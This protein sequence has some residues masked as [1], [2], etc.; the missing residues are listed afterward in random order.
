MRKRLS[1]CLSFW[2]SACLI[3]QNPLVESITIQDG[4]SQGMIYDLHQ[5]QEGFIWIATKDGLNR[6]DGRKFKHFNHDPFDPHSI[7][8]NTVQNIEEDGEG[9][10]WIGTENKG[11]N[12]FDKTTELFFNITRQEASQK[13]LTSLSVKDIVESPDGSMWIGT[14]FGLNQLKWIKQAPEILT[15]DFDFEEHIDLQHFFFKKGEDDFPPNIISNLMISSKK[16]IWLSNFGQNLRLDLDGNLLEDVIV[17]TQ[18]QYSGNCKLLEDLSGGIWISQ[19]GGLY[20]DQK[21]FWEKILVP[22]KSANDLGR[23]TLDANGNVFGLSTHQLLW[24]STTEPT[25]SLTVWLDFEEGEHIKR[26][27][28]M[29]DQSSNIWIGTGGY[30]IRKY[31]PNKKHFQH[32]LEGKSLQRIF[33]DKEDRIWILLLEEETYSAKILNEQTNQLEEHDKFKNFIMD[34]I[35]MKDG[36][37][38]GLGAYQSNIK[39]SKIVEFIEGQPAINYM[40]KNEVNNGKLVEDHDGNL[41]KTDSNGKLVKFSPQ[42]KKIQTFSFN[43]LVPNTDQSVA[44]IEDANKHIWIGTAHGLIRGIPQGDS[45]YF[46][47]FQN[48]PKDASSLNNNFVLSLHDDPDTPKKRLWIGTKG[49]GLNLLNKETGRIEHFSTKAGLPNNVIYGILVDGEKH[50][51]MSTNRGLSKFNP[52]EKTFEN[53]TVTDGLQDNEFNTLSYAKGND[54]RL[55]FGGINGLTAFYPEDLEASEFKPP[56]CITSL[57]INNELIHHKD[58]SKVLQFPIE[59]TESITLKHFQNLLSFEFAAL[60]YTNSEKNQY[61]HFF[62]GVDPD[63]VFTGNDNTANYANLAPGEYTFY[64]KGS[65]S[66]GIWNEEPTALKVTILPPWW[67]SNLAYALYFFALLGGIYA[68]Y[69]FQINR[70]KLQNQLAFEQKEAERLTELDRIKTNF[71]SNITHE[72]RTP[73]TLIIEPIRQIISKPEDT[74]WLTK[75]RLVETN[76]RKLLELVNQLLDLSKLE[77]RQMNLDLRNGNIQNVLRPIYQSFLPLAEKKGIVLKYNA[78]MDLPEF[79]FDKNKVEKVAYN[80]LSNALKFTKEGSCELSIAMVQSEQITISVSDTGLGIS[81]SEL[82]KVFDRFYQVDASSTREGEGT[83]IGLALTKELVELMGGN[84]E[85]ESE[86]GKGST[87][88]VTLPMQQEVS[89]NPLKKELPDTQALQRPQRGKHNTPTS[90]QRLIQHQNIIESQHLNTITFPQGQAQRP[91]ILIIEDNAEM[92]QFIKYSLPETFQI[93]EASNG[94]EGI[95]KAEELIPDL[96]I[97]DLMM[98]KKDGYE[99]TSFLKNDEKTSHIPII[100]LT[101]KSAIESK[102]QGLK[103]GADAYL[104]KPFHTE[105]L[106]VRIDKLIEIRKMMQEKFSQQPFSSAKKYSEKPISFFSKIDNDFLRRFTLLV[107]EYLEDENLSVEI[108]AKKMNLSRSQLHRKI[109]ALTG[110]APNDFVRNYRLDRA[111]ELLRNKEGN[112]MQ[113]SIMVGFGNEKYFSTRFKERFGKSPSEVK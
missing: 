74:D 45:I 38:W 61:Q 84:I 98:P 81:S 91:T 33:Q 83:G 104:T 69:R 13:G 62:E 75:L 60:D 94:E 57:K 16:E 97:S 19:P 51:W 53:Y 7:S 41:L 100:L 63:W 44:L 79:F 109:K 1:I 27:E 93:I 43:H 68:I 6:Y 42:S 3:A 14:D 82:P 21:G 66:S 111:M 85:A 107:D 37:F 35:Q 23:I 2:F 113:I 80:L 36:S 34:L 96:V 90:S 52:R 110:Q 56:V 48:D 58:S 50:L 102:I 71:F 9:R 112:V 76:S 77:G 73:L 24:K 103:Q 47:L 25:D 29:I 28:I 5:D 17:D 26:T 78:A 70:V 72:F 15:E 11:I 86:P 105:E 54:G 106:K 40:F 59:Q 20:N 89:Q 18:Y 8:G 12:L 49:G 31:N 99:V 95:R 22:K 67:K 92:R 55:F 108:L 88:R 101:A 10:L 46:V 65:N 4:L 64:V 39:G 30:G 32:Y 87:F